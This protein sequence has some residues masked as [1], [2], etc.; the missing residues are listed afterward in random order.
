MTR[1]PLRSLLVAL[2]A[3][4]ALPVGGA[5]QDDLACLACHNDVELLRAQASNGVDPIGLHVP[6][7]PLR[8][9]GHGDMTCAEC[10]TSFERFPHPGAAETVTCGTSS[11]H[12]NDP[13]PDWEGSVHARIQ[14]ETGIAAA[15]CTAC[16]GVHDVD[17]LDDLRVEGGP[18]MLRM[19]ASC[20]SCHEAQNHPADPHADTASCAGCHAPHA[21]R[22]IDS[23]DSWVAPLRQAETCAACHEAVTDSVRHDA[24][25]AALQRQG[26]VTP[27]AWPPNPADSLAPTCTDCH[28]AHP[29]AGPP[30]D[31]VSRTASPEMDFQMEMVRRCAAC[32]VAPAESYYLTYHGKATRLGS[33]VSAS[34]A[35]CHGAHGVF[36][37]DS[38]ASAIHEGRIVETCASCHEAARAAFVLYD[39]HPEPMNPD[40]NP[41]LFGSFVFMNA[42]LLGTLGVFFLHTA[43]WWLR[44]WLDMRSGR[45]HHHV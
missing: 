7:G 29:M 2:G 17:A 28:G 34:C 41:W 36:P 30:P 19:N 38:A 12:T 8:A 24:H 39:S 22:E 13:H 43:L 14:E 11:C 31:S 44:I 9:S 23:P 4:L 42:I 33:G 10:H 5:A 18:A 26:R 32:H 45:G 27:L 25:G 35:Q 21:M 16:H 6:P 15:E 3:L 20:I 37:A 1:A 40:R